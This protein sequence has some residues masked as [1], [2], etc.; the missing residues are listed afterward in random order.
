MWNTLILTL[1][2][3]IHLL[4]YIQNVFS[5]VFDYYK[6]QSSLLFMAYNL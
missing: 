1:Y 3:Y 5:L 2:N 6:N 4:D